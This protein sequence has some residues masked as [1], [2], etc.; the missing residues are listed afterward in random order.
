MFGIYLVCFMGGL[1][2]GL[3]YGTDNLLE[4]AQWLKRKF[5]C[6]ISKKARLYYTQLDIDEQLDNE[7]HRAMMKL[8]WRCILESAIACDEEDEQCHCVQK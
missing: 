6:T 3:A 4:A 8:A 1:A 5:L 2:F 7:R